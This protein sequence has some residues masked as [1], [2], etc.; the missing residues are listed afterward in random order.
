MRFCCICCS[1]YRRSHSSSERRHQYRPVP[2][3]MC[4]LV[5]FDL[6]SVPNPM[7]DDSGLKREE[8]FIANVSK[9]DHLGTPELHLIRS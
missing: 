2:G 3:L 8:R 6:L 7:F 1:L 4:D 5:L 9:L